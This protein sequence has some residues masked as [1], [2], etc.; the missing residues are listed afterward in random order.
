MA[1]LLVATTGGHL[2]QLVDIVDRLT[3]ADATDVRV[4]VTHDHPQS[5][6]LLA[7]QTTVYVP[8]VGEKDVRGVLRNVPVAHRL[9]R[10]EHVTRV[11][12]TGSGLALGYLPYFAARG[13][14]T[15]YIESATRVGGPSLTGQ[16]LRR[17]PRV[18]LYSQ[19]EHQA[20]GR[21]KYGGSVFDGF[22][23][24][25]RS[26]RAVIKRAV[27]T[28][29][30]MHEFAFRRMLEVVAPLLRPGGVIERDQGVPV[31]VVW[32]TGETPTDGL[33]L[34]ACK[35]LPADE[36]EAALAAAD[37]VVSHAGTGSALSSLRAGRCPVL[38]PRTAA[39]GEI[40]DDHQDRFARELERRGLALRR[41]VDQLTADDLFLAATRHVE[42]ATAAPSFALIA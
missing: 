5:R 2:T 7:G 9:L 41:P 31:E 8:H 27:V 21:W 14:P 23:A 38:I 24:T 30:T 13:V 39:D 18:H 15:H 16:L 36:M 1:T 20:S 25:V 26:E 22:S 29:G 4:W 6:S 37:V 12:S 10:S 32:Q 35:W 17:V 3:P 28:L 34:P 33:D 42:R 19:Y 40:G 11:V